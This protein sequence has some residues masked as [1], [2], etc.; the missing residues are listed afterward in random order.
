MWTKAKST[1]RQTNYSTNSKLCWHLVRLDFKVKLKSGEYV[2]YLSSLY[3]HNILSPIPATWIS[4]L[5]RHSQKFQIAF[6]VFFSVQRKDYLNTFDFIDKIAQCLTTEL[7]RWLLSSENTPTESQN[8]NSRSWKTCPE[9][10]FTSRLQGRLVLMRLLFRKSF[11]G[12]E[13]NAWNDVYRI[14]TNCS[15]VHKEIRVIFL[16][17]TL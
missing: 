15:N 14:M 4:I 6:F 10:S 5:R 12:Q 9:I 8:L 17:S 11:F 7:S 16:S 1:E 2:S 13:V 3:N